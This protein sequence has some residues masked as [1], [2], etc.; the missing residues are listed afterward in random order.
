MMRTKFRFLGAALLVAASG[1][2]AS[3]ALATTTPTFA[4]SS[5][6][7]NTASQAGDFGLSYNTVTALYQYGSRYWWTPVVT[8]WN[9]GTT[10]I[11]AYQEASLQ[12][13]SGS[14]LLTFDRNGDVYD[15]TATFST[16]ETVGSA[17]VPN[18]GSA[19]VLTKMQYPSGTLFP[20]AIHNI[21]IVD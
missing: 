14:K 6:H 3:R 13:G 17:D 5:G 18:D 8:Q 2:G 10:T 12:S 21:Y 7:A 19:G 9:F 15:S 4:A 1:L 11:S 16:T 20:D